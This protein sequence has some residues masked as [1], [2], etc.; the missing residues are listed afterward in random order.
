MVGMEKE[1]MSRPWCR[2]Q[3]AVLGDSLYIPFFR[4]LK[5]KSSVYYMFGNSKGF[6]PTSLCCDI[7]N[8]KLSLNWAGTNRFSVGG[9][10]SLLKPTVELIVA[11]NNQA[12]AFMYIA[13]PQ[14]LNSETKQ[15]LQLL[16]TKVQST[17]RQCRT[18]LPSLWSFCLPFQHLLVLC[19]FISGPENSSS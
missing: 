8:S 9:D 18:W 19:F 11:D 14:D 2:S 7:G 1:G 4:K 16:N 15:S 3:K 5:P 17:Q 6:S 13:F 12:S 10:Q